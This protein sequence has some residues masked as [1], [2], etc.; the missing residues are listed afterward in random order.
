MHW[1][2]SKHYAIIVYTTGFMVLIANSIDDTVYYL[3]VVKMSAHD[4]SMTNKILVL[5]YRTYSNLT[6]K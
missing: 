5:F 6:L 3:W 2:Y 1:Q 4:I